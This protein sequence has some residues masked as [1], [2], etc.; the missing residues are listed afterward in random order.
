MYVPKF[1]LFCYHLQDLLNIPLP[2]NLCN[3]VKD[4]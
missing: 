3:P 4:V 2:C 1:N